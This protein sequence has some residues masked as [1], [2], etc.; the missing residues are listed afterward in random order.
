MASRKRIASD[1]TDT[2][3]AE[4]SS[5]SFLGRMADRTGIKTLVGS[6]AVST[7]SGAWSYALTTHANQYLKQICE[8]APAL[9]TSA[10]NMALQGVRLAYKVCESRNTPWSAIGANATLGISLGVATLAVAVVGY[11]AYQW[12][13]TP[14]PKRQRGND[15]GVVGQAKLSGIT[16][17]PNS[18][19]DLKKS[20]GI[21]CKGIPFDESGLFD[22]PET[23]TKAFLDFIGKPQPSVRDQLCRIFNALYSKR[24]LW[25]SQFILPSMS[26][27]TVVFVKEKGFLGVQPPNGQPAWE[28]EATKIYDDDPNEICEKLQELVGPEI[29]LRSR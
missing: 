21:A 19:Y 4:S 11:K 25:M 8:N 20:F 3:E 15:G 28:F 27:K 13:A 2:K 7:G 14:N 23:V 9:A 12:F 6:A 29:Q 16:V 24:Y 26:P 10:Q 5:S 1:D 18:D 17:N 22:Q